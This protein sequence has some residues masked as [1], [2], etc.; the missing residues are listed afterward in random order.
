MANMKTTRKA[1]TATYPFPLTG[2]MEEI[3]RA[4]YFYRYITAL[5]MAH[6]F[7]SPKSLN[8]V[9]GILCDLAGGADF[10][11]NQYLC[12]F[13]L[14]G[15]SSG[16][17]EKIY[18]LGSRGRDFLDSVAEMP[19]GGYFRP[20]KLRHL[21]HSHVAHHLTLTRFLVAASVWAARQPDFRL[22]QV[23]TGYE[24]VRTPATVSLT[25]AGNP[26]TVKV[27]PDAWLL[28]ERL[29]EG[30][31]A[32]SFPILLE[33]DKGTTYSQK[34]KQQVRSRIE[35]IKKGGA[36]SQIFG[37]EAVLIAYATTGERPEYAENRRRTLATWTQEVLTELGKSR[38][39]SVFRFHSLNLEEIYQ[40]PLFETPVWYLPGS[41]K[42]VRLF[43]V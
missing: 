30:Q 33:I 15:T 9:R 35:F 40:S 13:Q 21:S 38:W 11:N 25:G 41:E 8:Y 2:R 1:K 27:V 20:D 12:R 32:T 4:V 22:S 24:L 29:T 26:Q 42:A 34:F 3:L 5:D 28:F 7:F 37:T 18:A 36:Y 31:G 19:V 6:L 23:R 43:P 16:R 17:R 10:Q 39:A 14:P